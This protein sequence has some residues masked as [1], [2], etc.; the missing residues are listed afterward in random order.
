MGC[1]EHRLARL[2]RLAES[3]HE[4]KSGSTRSMEH[5]LHAVE[6]AHREIEGREPL[7]ELPYTEE[8]RRDDEEF[9]R[10][11]LPAYRASPGWQT[12]EAQ[13]ILNE[14]EKHTLHSLEHGA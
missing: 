5:F 9:L 12:E 3:P 14:W 1:I 4:D 8:D 2:E 11:T 13:R 6:N 7:P 10:E